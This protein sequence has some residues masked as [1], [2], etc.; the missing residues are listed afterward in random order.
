MNFPGNQSGS[1]LSRRQWLQRNASG[2]GTLALANLLSNDGLA[3]DEGRRDTRKGLLHVVLR[4]AVHHTAPPHAARAGGVRELYDIG[5][6]P[7]G[8]LLRYTINV[9]G[10]GPPRGQVPL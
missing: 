10:F 3:A 7:A 8:A 5:A 2:F 6:G 9:D 4:D 1:F